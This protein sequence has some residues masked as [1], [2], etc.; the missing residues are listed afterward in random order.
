MLQLNSTQNIDLIASWCFKKKF[1]KFVTEQ[2]S[3]S[4]RYVSPESENSENTDKG[5]QWV[6]KEFYKV[7]IQFNLITVS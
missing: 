3:W 5:R 4:L 1:C 2:G 7:L 6:P